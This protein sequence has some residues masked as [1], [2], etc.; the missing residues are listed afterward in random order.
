MAAGVIDLSLRSSRKLTRGRVAVRVCL[1]VTAIIVLLAMTLLP[2][3]GIG[4]T[5]GVET[6]KN[7]APAVSERTKPAI[8]GSLHSA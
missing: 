7:G 8:A 3:P 2:S 5:P 6:R 4:Q 1:V